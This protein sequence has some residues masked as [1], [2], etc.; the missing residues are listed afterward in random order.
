MVID[1]HDHPVAHVRWRDME[2]FYRL[3]AMNLLPCLEDTELIDTSPCELSYAASDG[4]P[5]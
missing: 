5:A 1:F 3:K 4:D 2:Q